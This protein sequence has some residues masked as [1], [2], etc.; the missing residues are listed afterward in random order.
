MFVLYGL[1]MNRNKKIGLCFVLGLGIGAT[2]AAFYK[3][4]RLPELY[5]VTDYTYASGGLAIWS[6]VE[7]NIMIIAANL[8]TLRP[9]FL[10]VTRGQSSSNSKSAG[11]QGSY[12]LHSVG[13]NSKNISG[14]A[15]AKEIYP[16]DTVNL[17]HPGDEE[18]GVYQNTRGGITRTT[19][20]TVT[21]ED[22]GHG[23]GGGDAE[24]GRGK[25]TW[26]RW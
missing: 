23:Q 1:K 24:K 22:W 21:S 16:T 19:S 2:V 9:I 10:A 13:R 6:S 3:C 12:K 15:G 11:I 18:G 20:T 7:P 5:D 8:P 14:H 17:V 25:R 26:E 4:S